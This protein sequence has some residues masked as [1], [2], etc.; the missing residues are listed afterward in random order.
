M[1]VQ[2]KKST[3]N[4]LSSATLLTA[5]TSSDVSGCTP[6][7][8]IVGR[9]LCYVCGR[10]SS[11]FG[12]FWNFQLTWETLY[13]LAQVLSPS[14]KCE[15]TTLLRSCTDGTDGKMCGDHGPVAH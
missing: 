9:T 7:G 10:M 5:S 14:T 15:K 8:K 4:H 12:T 11:A 6:E 2:K 3:Q 13:N 1:W